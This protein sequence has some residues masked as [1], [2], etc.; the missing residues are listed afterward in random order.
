[1]NIINKILIP[2]IL[3]LNI[4]VVFRF[5]IIKSEQT[6][7]NN[8]TLQDNY[9]AHINDIVCLNINVLYYQYM[10]DGFLIDPETKLFRS[11]GSSF[12]ISELQNNLPLL[13]FFIKNV[14]CAICIENEIGLINSFVGNTGLS[15]NVLIIK[16]FSTLRQWHVFERAHQLRVYS[17]KNSALMS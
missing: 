11:D 4:F 2:L 13:T 10:N 5:L 16:E 15:E 12:S 7:Y 8:G 17:L 3:L 14:G 1:M 6:N 9:G